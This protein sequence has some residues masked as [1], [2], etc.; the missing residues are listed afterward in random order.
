MSLGAGAMAGLYSILRALTTGGVGGATWKF[1]PALDRYIFLGVPPVI[2]FL[3]DEEADSG[4]PFFLLLLILILILMVLSFGSGTIVD[5]RASSLTSFS[6]SFAGAS[7]RSMKDE[8]PTLSVLALLP[9][10]AVP[11][12]HLSLLLSL[13]LFLLL[14]SFSFLLLMQWSDFCSTFNVCTALL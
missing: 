14:F 11:V 5:M 8:A 9:L 6:C 3:H 12:F 2:F 13:L 10:R 1:V 4:G 7:A